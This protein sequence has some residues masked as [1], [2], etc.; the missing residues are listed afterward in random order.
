LIG[1]AG[2]LIG[3]PLGRSTDVQDLSAQR[4]AL[5]TLGIAP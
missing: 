3:D 4:S 2:R 5:A 1:Y